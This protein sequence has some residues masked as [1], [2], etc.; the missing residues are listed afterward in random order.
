MHHFINIHHGDASCRYFPYEKAISVT[1]AL[2]NDFV[3]LP[4]HFERVFCCDGLVCGFGDSA[5]LEAFTGRFSGFWPDQVVF[6]IG[7]RLPN[8]V[9]RT[10]AVAFGR[11]CV[12]AVSLT[13]ML[14]SAGKGTP[15]AAFC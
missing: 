5:H 8:A 9:F 12:S 7:S 2:K 15:T 10:F 3:A 1:A 4:A 11:R 14:K 13:L 6:S